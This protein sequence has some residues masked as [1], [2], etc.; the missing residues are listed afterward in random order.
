[1]SC[2]EKMSIQGIRSFGPDD[3][4][5]G[6]IIFFSPLTLILGPNGT[7]KTVG[8]YDALIFIAHEFYLWYYHFFNIQYQGSNKC[9]RVIRNTSILIVLLLLNFLC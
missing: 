6:V 1:M 3:R 5:K 4:D 9:F 7:G 2:I 8:P